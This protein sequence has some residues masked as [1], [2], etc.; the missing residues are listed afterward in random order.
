MKLDGNDREV[1]ELV[2]RELE[3]E[4]NSLILIASE[5]YVDADVLAMQGCVLTNKY[6]EGYPHK[7]Y[8]SGCRYLDDIESIAIERTKTLFKAEHANV[9]PHSGSS[10]NMGVFFV[11][12]DRGD[13]VLGMDIA[14]GGHLTHGAAPSFS[15]KWYHAVSYGVSSESEMLDY[16]EIRRI[17]RR[18]KPKL[19]IAGASAYSKTID[20]KRFRE[21]ADEVGAYLLV[22]MAHIAG[23]VAA[24]LHPD[25]VPYA[26]FVTTTTHKTLRGPRGGLILCKNEFAKKIDSAIFPGIQG[27]PLMHVIAAKAVALKAAMTD[28]F[29]EYQ[30]QIIRNAQY[31]AGCMS[32]LGFRIVSGGTDNHLF[33]VDLTAKNVTGKEAQE[34]LEESGIMVNKNLIPFDK[35][36]PNTAS[37][38]R[39]GTPAVT[40]RG[41]KEKEMEIICELIDNVLRDIN[42]VKLRAD[43]QEKVRTLCKQ[44]PFYSRIYDI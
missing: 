15:G 19:I 27:G 25:P 30:K 18:E 22:D 10:A 28:E 33:L 26:H 6:A 5:N 40:T 16:D 8:Y 23:L 7:R 44:F 24:G 20:F 42:N 11:A 37:G 1:F 38:I 32:R 35:K 4:E 17:A 43:T 31:M 13:T 36:N 21:I 9:Q 41:M 12:L 34:A 29:R 2:N 3:R 14:H 39:I